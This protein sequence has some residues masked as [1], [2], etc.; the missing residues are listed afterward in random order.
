[1]IPFG[2]RKVTTSFFSTL[3]TPHI[4]HPAAHELRIPLAPLASPHWVSPS[5]PDSPES[6]GTNNSFPSFFIVVI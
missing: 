5:S 6:L 3:S 1:M 4:S 2:T